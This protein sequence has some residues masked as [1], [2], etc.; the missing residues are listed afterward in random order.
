MFTSEIAP[1]VRRL[2]LDVPADK[3][4]VLEE[5]QAELG[6]DSLKELFSASLSLMGW[7]CDVVRHGRTIASVDEAN[8]S[9]RELRMDCLQRLRE[10]QVARPLA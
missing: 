4:E 8:Q 9:L 3:L 6:M 5:L 7:A 10:R 1:P 2:Q